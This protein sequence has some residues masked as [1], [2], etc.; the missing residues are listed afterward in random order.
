M[1]SVLV[2]VFEVA[3]DN[4]LN[5]VYP[6]GSYM[7]DEGETSN[8]CF[9]TTMVTQADESVVIN[10]HYRDEPGYI[11]D[12]EITFSSTTVS[13]PSGSDTA[14]ITITGV[15]DDIPLE[16]REILEFTI[17]GVSSGLVSGRSGFID[18]IVSD[19]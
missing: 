18:I 6:R 1:S 8:M 16:R 3:E 13:F 4:L 2:G 7:V 9:Y 17:T 5:A 15:S 12:G 19:D 14:C 10:P 11:Q